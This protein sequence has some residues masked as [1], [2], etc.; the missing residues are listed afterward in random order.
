VKQLRWQHLQK[1]KSDERPQS[2][3]PPSASKNSEGRPLHFTKSGV[4]QSNNNKSTPRTGHD[5][6]APSN[7]QSYPQRIKCY[8]C[9]STEHVLQDCPVTLPMQKKRLYKEMKKR[10]A[11]KHQA[12]STTT[13]NIHDNDAVEQPTSYDKQPR[14]VPTLVEANQAIRLGWNGQTICNTLPTRT[15]YA[16]MVLAMPPAQIQNIPI[17]RYEDEVYLDSGASDHMTGNITMLTGIRQAASNVILPDGSIVNATAAGTL[18]VSVHNNRSGRRFVI[19]LLDTLYVPGLTKTL[20][21]VTQFTTKGHLVIFGTDSVTIMLNYNRPR[22]VHIEIP[23]PFYHLSQMPLPFAMSA[24]ARVSYAYSTDAQDKE[25][26][27]PQEQPPID[28]AQATTEITPVN[29]QERT[30]A[31][32]GLELIHNQLGHLSTQTILSADEYNMWNYT[33]VRQETDNFYY[34]CKIGSIRKVPRTSNPVDTRATKPGQVLCMDII[35]NPF[36]QSV[37]T[38]VHSPYYLIIV[39]AFSRYCTLVGI[40]SISVDNTIKAIEYHCINYGPK[41]GFTEDDID[42]VHADAGSQFTSDAFSQWAAAHR[43][44]V[45]LAAP[46]HQHQNGIAERRWQHLRV[47]AFKILTHARLPTTYFDLAI[48]Y[49]WMVAN[50]IPVKGLSVQEGDEVK[51][52]TPYYKYFSVLPNIA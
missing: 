36:K 39:C 35:S 46:E 8:G 40:Q 43:I 27:D 26:I 25:Y 34:G 4:Q 45:C 48:Q 47:I 28:A 38:K 29:T 23:H 19:P 5:T 6:V 30:K 21:S 22:E 32:V 7:E 51:P 10:F 11:A 52:T 12:N 41:L 15:A 18:R 3:K 44:S 14:P 49:A 50:V 24:R 13:A 1:T 31:K 33:I 17:I 42:C 2:R 20:W 16:N 37:V 9:Q